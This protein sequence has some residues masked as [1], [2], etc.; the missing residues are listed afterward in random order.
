ML[1]SGLPGNQFREIPAVPGA[2]QYLGKREPRLPTS[3]VFACESLCV[4]GVSRDIL[5]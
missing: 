3:G 2:G 5:R 1:L 4:L